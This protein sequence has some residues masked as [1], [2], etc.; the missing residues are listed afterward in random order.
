[1]TTE[2]Y[3]REMQRQREIDE[4]RRQSSSWTPQQHDE[5]HRARTRN[6]NEMAVQAGRIAAEAKQARDFVVERLTREH[7]AAM[8]PTPWR[9]T[10]AIP[11]REVSNPHWYD[12]GTSSGWD[13][14]SGW[15][16]WTEWNAWSADSQPYWGRDNTSANYT[17]QVDQYDPNRPTPGASSS[18]GRKGKGIDRQVKGKGVDGQAKGKRR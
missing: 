8:S 3:Q 1:M 15:N 5:D 16:S 13:N 14:W 12:D 7:A 6:M 17:G 9:P 18:S 10:L 4:Q 2:A 11:Q